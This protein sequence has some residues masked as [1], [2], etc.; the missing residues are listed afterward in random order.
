MR[1]KNR[2]SFFTEM[3][4]LSSLSMVLVSSCSL[5]Y[6]DPP[7]R[8][9]HGDPL[10]IYMPVDPGKHPLLMG[11][12]I[13]AY[14]GD[15]VAL[16]R[17]LNLTGSRK[18]GLAQE[19]GVLLSKILNPLTLPFLAK[20]LEQTSVRGIREAV[21][22][23]FR[24]VSS[25][26]ERKVILTL[27]SRLGGEAQAVAEEMLTTRVVQS[28][29][30]GSQ[31]SDYFLDTLEQAV[32][33]D[34][35]EARRLSMVREFSRS[36]QYKDSLLAEFLRVEESGPRITAAARLSR[37]ADER[38][39][40]YV[41]ELAYAEWKDHA[42]RKA[43]PMWSSLLVD[44]VR[45][46]SLNEG[47]Y[48]AMPERKVLYEAVLTAL[49]GKES[50]L[51]DISGDHVRLQ[52]PHLEEMKRTRTLYIA[53]SYLEGIEELALRG[54][55]VNILPPW[56]LRRIANRRERLFREFYIGEIYSYGDCSA[57]RVST[58]SVLPI[59][60]LRP[61]G[62]IMYCAADE[63]WILLKKK[64]KEWRLLSALLP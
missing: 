37:T 53:D 16:R 44:L 3:M 60:P 54:Y 1:Q 59:R 32:L 25:P 51:R 21:K 11:L 41:E 22:S 23:S 49:F 2:A 19:A 14:D 62:G 55:K 31:V 40:P 5:I 38:L 56:E 13:K 4:L 34:G 26:Q 18:A 30:W 50:A 57:L 15:T 12:A 47:T 52:L 48:L 33:I 45:N 39:L 9:I 63:I 28:S 20:T 43:M 24:S 27:A 8:G 42:S 6:V 10:Y 17:L 46:L 7:P 58:C 61:K 36:Q 29:L 35:E 64:G